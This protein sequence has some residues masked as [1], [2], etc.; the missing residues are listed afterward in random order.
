MTM[1]LEMC[2][3]N[4]IRH[5]VHIEVCLLSWEHSGV[6]FLFRIYKKM[7]NDYFGQW[8]R[9]YYSQAQHGLNE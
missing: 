9:K 2:M 6:S 4:F 3:K 5:S 7:L 1:T 8:I